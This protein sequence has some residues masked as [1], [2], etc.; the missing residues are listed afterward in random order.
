VIEI[1]IIPNYDRDGFVVILITPSFFFEDWIGDEVHP[2]REIHSQ[3]FIPFQA[4]LNGTSDEYTAALLTMHV[5]LLG[6]P[7]EGTQL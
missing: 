3:T 6:F 7:P 5:K 2:P 1:T 4:F